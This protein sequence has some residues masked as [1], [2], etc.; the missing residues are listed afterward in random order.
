MSE[1]EKRVWITRDGVDE[2]TLGLENYSLG[3]K[4]SVTD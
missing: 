1:H 3:D 4:D 2:K